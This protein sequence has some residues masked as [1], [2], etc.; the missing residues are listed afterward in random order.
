MEITKKLDSLVRTYCNRPNI[1][2]TW[3]E[4]KGQADSIL[5]SYFRS[6]A[7]MGTKPQDAYFLKMGVETMTA[8]DIGNGKMILQAGVATLKPAE[9]KIITIEKIN[10]WR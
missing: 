10:S 5:L 7:L 1:Q 8:T 3:T 9:F 4:I 2:T 6:G